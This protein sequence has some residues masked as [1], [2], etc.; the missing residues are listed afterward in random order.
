MP[1]VAGVVG[2]AVIAAARFL[3]T[4]SARLPRLHDSRRELTA[5]ERTTLDAVFRGGLDLDAITVVSGRAGVLD[6]SR[7]PVTLG[8]TI[9]LRGATSPGVLVHEAVHVWQYRDRGARYVVDALV[10]QASAAPYDWR[11]AGATR[12]RDLD[13]ECQAQFVQDLHDGRVS[14]AHRAL[15]DDALATLALPP[16]R[17]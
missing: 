9:Y 12:W 10:A 17:P 13:V 1:T 8:T 6:L 7:R 15:A 11:A 14:P 4:A 16:P 2:T 3:T 5:T